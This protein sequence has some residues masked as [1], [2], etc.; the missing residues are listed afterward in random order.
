MRTDKRT[1]RETDMAKLIVA[2]QNFSNAPIK[3]H[4]LS[5]AGDCFVKIVLSSD[6][7]RRNYFDHWLFVF[8]LLEKE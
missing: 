2:F 8:S 5:F 7:V 4:S 3:S 6:A 1:A